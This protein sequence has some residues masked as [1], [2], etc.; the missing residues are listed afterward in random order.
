[1]TGQDKRKSNL[2]NIY[3]SIV[4][5]AYNR[6]KTLQYCLDS[7]LDQSYPYFEVIIVDDA[8]SDNTVN[9]I[10][11]YQDERIKL[12]EQKENRGAQ[13]C[14]N[15]GIKNAQY[16]WI[17]FLDSDDTWNNDKLAKQIEEL[18]KWNTPYIVIHSDALLIDT[19]NKEEKIFGISR[20]EG[21]N[22]Y[23]LLLTRP[24]PMFQAILTSKQALHE[25][26]Y[27]DENV[28]S[29]QE[30]DT[31]IRL[32]KICRFIQLPSPT[33]SYYYHTGETISKN[34]L[35]DLQGYDYIMTKFKADIFKYHGKRQWKQHLLIQYDKCMNW[36]MYK[37]AFHYLNLYP[38]CSK[39]IELYYEFFKDC[40]K[41][42]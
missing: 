42:R 20:T 13:H 33:F 32:A 11:S 9:I 5:P 16:D 6:E 35:R 8:S 39:K 14:R 41:N 4:I 24:A 23:P 2:N 26:G 36:K 37:E 38:L 27:L 19:I 15:V 31:S 40:I 21:E 34:K 17:A 18:K 12:I 7:V 28:P 1:M 3:I 25:I 10:K 29:Y 22:V 30:W